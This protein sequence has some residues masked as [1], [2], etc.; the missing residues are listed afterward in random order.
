LEIAILDGHLSGGDPAR[1]LDTY[2]VRSFAD[3]DPFVGRVRLAIYKNGGCTLYEECAA[4]SVEFEG[5]GLRAPRNLQYGAAFG[6]SGERHPELVPA[7]Y[8]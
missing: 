2:L 7:A 6:I 1:C 4:L 8:A 5:R 3:P